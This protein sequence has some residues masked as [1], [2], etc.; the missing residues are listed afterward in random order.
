MNPSWMIYLGLALLSIGAIGL[1]TQRNLIKLVMS[2]EL[3][4]SSVCM[5]SV[6]YS[7]LNDVTGQVLAIYLMAI[8]AAEVAVGAG[9]IIA[10]YRL[11]N[12][13]DLEVYGRL[14]G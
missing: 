4:I 8:A 1:A 9:I 11:S 2:I 6:G 12:T 13:V 14:R 5:I 7:L 10:A 3:M